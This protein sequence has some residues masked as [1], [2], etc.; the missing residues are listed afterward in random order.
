MSFCFNERCKNL[1]ELLWMA[2]RLFC[3][4][5]IRQGYPLSPLAFVLSADLL[6]ITIRDCKGTKGITTLL[7]VVNG[8]D[9]E[10][11]LKI[12]SYADDITLL[13]GNEQEMSHALSIINNLSRVS[14]LV[15]NKKKSEAM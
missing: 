14:G 13:G 2:F 15:I 7:D 12:A 1:C 8:T 6:A 11:V 9:L 4:S 5:G 10:Q 3:D